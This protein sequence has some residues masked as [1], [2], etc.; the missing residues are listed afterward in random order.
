MLRKVVK[1]IITFIATLLFLA[2]IAYG[3]SKSSF[4][5]LKKYDEDNPN[6]NH[7]GLKEQIA[8][9]KYYTT[10]VKI[11]NDSTANLGDFTINISNNKKLIT[12]ISLKFINQKKND[13]I[14]DNGVKKEMLKKGDVL[15]SVIIDTIS[16]TED[17]SIKNKRMKK[18]IVENLNKYLSDGKVTEVY[19][20]KFITQ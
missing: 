7:S 8:K 11:E 16:H 14:L 18:D 4:N 17:A 2:L 5:N 10:E 15:R 12:N 9:N 19:F 1:I 6:S 13:W 20:N 3:V